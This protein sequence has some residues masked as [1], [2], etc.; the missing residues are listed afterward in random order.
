MKRLTHWYISASQF[1]ILAISISQLL[2]AGFLH[3]VFARNP[4]AAIAT[5]PIQHVVVIM[6]ENHTFDNYFGTF[7]HANGL[8]LPRA[9]DPAPLD[10]NHNGAAAAAAMDGGQMDEFPLRE[11][12]QY[13]QS[14]IPNYWDY[15]QSFGLGDDFFTSMATSS[16]PNHIAM[17]AA[18]NGDLYETYNQHGCLS[19]QNN[20]IYS[21]QNTGNPYWSYPCHDVT[22]LPQELDANSL[23][24]RYYSTTGIW[25]A[26]EMIQSLVGSSNDVH[27]ETQFIQDV[28]WG[29]MANVSMSGNNYLAGV[30]YSYTASS[31]SVGEY[32]YRFRVDDG[33][34]VAIFEEGVKP[35]ITPI[36]LTGSSVSSTSGNSST[37]FTFSTTY[38]NA[39]GNAPAQSDLYVDKAAYPM[40]LVSGSFTTE[41]LYQSTIT[42]PS[43]NHSFY[44][45]FS[46]PNTTWADPFAPGSYAGPIPM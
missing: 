14:D 24:W 42:L 15:A 34:G 13:T 9:T 21:K 46:D 6:M 43:G 10:F 26:P 23:S 11:H 7:P 22:N 36:T 2:P 3:R 8:A 44:F 17:I 40:T 19:N 1:I 27:S 39:N 41:A 29:K 25:D 12:V 35:W 31:L 45:V 30:N 37:P 28:Q 18:Q 16:S 5:T 33:S 32:Y 20:L 4:K 38:T